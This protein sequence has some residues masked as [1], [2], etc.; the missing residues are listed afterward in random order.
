MLE[1]WTISYLQEMALLFSGRA[2]K[3][4]KNYRPAS[5]ISIPG[6]VTEQIAF[7]HGQ[8]VGVVSMDSKRGTRAWLAGRACWTYWVNFVKTRNWTGEVHH[9]YSYTSDLH[10]K[11]KCKKECI[12]GEIFTCRSSFIQDFFEWF[13]HCRFFSGKSF[14][15]NE[16]LKLPIANEII[17]LLLKRVKIHNF[18]ILVL[19][20]VWLL[21]FVTPNE[22][23]I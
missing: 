16:A 6:N 8:E 18:Q 2:R 21:D 4:T 10:I 20:T 1:D 7:R 14:K 3:D 19:I 22:A 23:K 17:K 5:L 11:K 12:A 15:V 9:A 13:L